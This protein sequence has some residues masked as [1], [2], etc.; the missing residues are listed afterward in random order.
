MFSKILTNSLYKEPS[1]E[2]PVLQLCTFDALELFHIKIKI[3]DFIS[4]SF[5]FFI[6]KGN[7][8]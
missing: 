2:E 4:T 8:V 7:E 5:G 6:R 3:Q 1:L